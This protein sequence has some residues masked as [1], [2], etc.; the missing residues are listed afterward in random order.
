MTEVHIRKLLII[1]VL[2]HKKIIDKSLIAVH[3]KKKVLR[4]NKPIYIGF[5]VLELS[6]LL[7]YLFHYDYVLKTFN[8]RLLFTNT[9]SLVYELEVVMFM[10]S[11]LKITICLILVNMI[12]I[13]FIIV[14]VVRKY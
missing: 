4:L 1:L 2:Y 3:C 14:V 9:D 12:K 6:K 7:K 13:V 8:S 5:C 10:N 11:I